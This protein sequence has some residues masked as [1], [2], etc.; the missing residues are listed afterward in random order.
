MGGSVPNSAGDTAQAKGGIDDSELMRS[1]SK[2]QQAV[3]GWNDISDKIASTFESD[4]STS[5]AC[6]LGGSVVVMIANEAL[7]FL[8]RATDG[9]QGQ[10][11]QNAMGALPTLDLSPCSAPPL[12]LPMEPSSCTRPLMACVTWLRQRSWCGLI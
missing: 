4:L 8:S 10:E 9:V 6:I 1:Q 5:S 3:A 7:H 11:F 2:K 12:S